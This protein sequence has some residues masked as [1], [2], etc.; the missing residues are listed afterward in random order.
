VRVRAKRIA[1]ATLQ[2][3][4]LIQMIILEVAWEH[5]A[6]GCIL[7]VDRIHDLF[8]DTLFAKS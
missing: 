3:P 7:V 6:Q 4:K 2:C 5:R 8:H 1:L